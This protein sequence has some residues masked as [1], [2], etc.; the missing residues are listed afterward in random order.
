MQNL[1][2]KQSVVWAIGKWSIAPRVLT[3]SRSCLAV[4]VVIIIAFD[5]EGE[6]RSN[7]TACSLTWFSDAQDRYMFPGERNSLK[8]KWRRKETKCRREKPFDLRS[9]YAKMI[10][11]PLTFLRCLRIQPFFFRSVPLG[12][13]RRRNVPSGEEQGETTVFASYLLCLLSFSVPGDASE[14][15]EHADQ[16][17]VCSEG[18]E[19]LCCDTCPL[20]YHIHCVYPPLRRIPRGN[21]A[22]QVC[23]GADDERPRS[24]RVKKAT[25]EGERS[26]A[27]DSKRVYATLS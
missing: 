3:S 26:L 19:L 6:W 9:S 24:C 4:I 23:T 5:K 2:G 18:G 13:F 10:L 25:I 15:S 21:W 11:V 7:I 16:C 12:T 22:C 8:P 17:A 20:A 14:S 1:G 27:S